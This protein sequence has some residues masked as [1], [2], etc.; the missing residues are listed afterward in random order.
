[1]K[2]KLRSETVCMLTILVIVCALA[3]AIFAESEY[4][5]EED[6][7]S[8]KHGDCLWD[9]AEEYCPSTMNAWDYICLIMERNNLKSADIYPGQRLIVYRVRA[10]SASLYGGCTQVVKA[11]TGNLGGIGL[12]RQVAYTTSLVRIQPSS[13]FIS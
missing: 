3:T 9:I 8:V 7:Y 2:I 1:M 5:F 13:S 10:H 4:D 12:S 6:T 11:K